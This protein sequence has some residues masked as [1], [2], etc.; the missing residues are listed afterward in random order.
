LGPFGLRPGAGEAGGLPADSGG[1][2]TMWKPAAREDWPGVLTG[3]E[4]NPIRGSDGEGA[5][6]SLARD[7]DGGRS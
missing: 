6:R 4:G 3:A 5:H 7:G 1:S 2:T